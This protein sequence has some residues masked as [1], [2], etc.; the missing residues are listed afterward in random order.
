MKDLE[1]HPWVEHMK[2]THS[3]ILRL[4]PEKVLFK[5]SMQGNLIR[6]GLGAHRMLKDLIAIGC[7]DSNLSGRSDSNCGHTTAVQII[8]LFGDCTKIGKAV[9]RQCLCFKLLSS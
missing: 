8:P 4:L 9:L 2:T 6:K 3:F 1:L 7:S 5:A